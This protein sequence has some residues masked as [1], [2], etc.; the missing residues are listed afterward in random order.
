[1]PIGTLTREKKLRLEI[2][3]AA[4]H[5]RLEELRKTPIIE[6]WRRELGDLSRVL[7]L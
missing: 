6:I 1:M 2:E 5:K 4:L 3:S 7:G